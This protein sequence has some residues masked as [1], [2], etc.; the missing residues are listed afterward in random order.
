MNFKLKH[1]AFLLLTVALFACKD[2]DKKEKVVKEETLKPISNGDLENAVIY[3]A[4]IRQ[5]SPEGTFNA[6]TKDIP[7]L[8]KLGVKIIWL[9]PVFP[10]SHKNRKAKGDLMVED[11][12]DMQERTKY[13][14]SYYAVADYN[15]VNPDLGTE[16]DLKNLIKT[17][18]DNGIYVILDWVANHSG[19]DNPWIN[20][21]PEYYTKNEK[22]E[23]IHPEGTD[24]TDTA[25]LDYSNEGL[26]KAMRESME[27]WVREFDIDGYRCDVADKVPTDFWVDTVGALK[28]IKPVF[29]LAESEQKDLF[30]EAFDMG[31]NWEGHHLMNGLAQGKNTVQ[32]WDSYMERVDSLYQ[33]DDILMNFITN[34]DENSWNG[35]VKERMGDAGEAMLVMSYAIPGM[36]LLYSG[37]EYGMEKRLKFFEKDTIPK[38]KGHIWNVME[39][40]ADVKNNNPALHGGKN[41]AAYKRLKTSDDATIYAF[42]RTNQGRRVVYFF[43]ASNKSKHF[44]VPTVSGKLLE[45][46]RGGEL[47]VQEGHTFSFPPYG[48]RLFEVVQ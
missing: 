36:P 19:W 43:N 5:Y 16:A 38:Q 25:D 15:R 46:S 14:G 20:D 2:T 35:S 30:E 22:G 32:E 23:M 34:H 45:L 24:W 27:Y 48:Y 37:Q 42:E 47:N 3:E 31:Y 29:M 26:R 13:L 6:F 41:A 17:A 12:P 18:H 7:E 28:Q 10:I 39:R 8:K 33:E 4:N 11:I 1:A 21:H 40:L 9:M 44:E